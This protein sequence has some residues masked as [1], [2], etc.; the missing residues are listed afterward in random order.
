MRNARLA[1]TLIALLSATALA[2][3]VD[4]GSKSQPAP[5]QRAGTASGWAAAT[6]DGLG[7]SANTCSIC[8]RRV[9]TSATVVKGCHSE[10]CDTGEMIS[11]HQ[12]F[13]RDRAPEI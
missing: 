6:V 9:L 7:A 13:D 3:C 5:A 12:L 2:G 4:G 1:M 8:Q 11:G 10:E